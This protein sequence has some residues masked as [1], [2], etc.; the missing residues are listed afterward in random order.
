MTETERLE[1]LIGMLKDRIGDKNIQAIILQTYIQDYGPV[2][3]AY[4][5]QIK[6]LLGKVD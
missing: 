3:D 2:P 4:G 6:N 5:E 1:L